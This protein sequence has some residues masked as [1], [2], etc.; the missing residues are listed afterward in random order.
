MK[1]DK[2]IANN[3]PKDWFSI[4]SNECRLYPI[5][6]I[7]IGKDEL[8]LDIGA[9]VGGFWNVWRDISNNWELV[10]PSTY[11]CE[12]I[13]TNTPITPIQKAVYHTSDVK[14]KLQKYWGDGDNDTLSGN[15]GTTE[16]VNQTNNHGWR[17]EYEEVSTISFD[18]L[19]RGREVGLLKIDCEGG[20]YDFLINAEL[21]NVKYIVGEFHN[22]LGKEKQD[23]LF[24]HITKTHKEL[25]S[26][27]D[28][29][30]SH[31]VKLWQ[32]KN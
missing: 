27:G 24:G 7:A 12:Q 16:Y 25:F 19:V 14:L 3:Q 9:N 32:L 4:V 10:E 1:V 2:L 21:S 28:G 23:L 17:G 20:E 11:N 30:N 31:F 15:F 18:D 13:K 26:D 5:R 29:V 8:I 6:D 22:F